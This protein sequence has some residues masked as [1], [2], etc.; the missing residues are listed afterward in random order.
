MGTVP[1]V[2]KIIDVRNLATIFTFAALIALMWIALNTENHQKTVII[3]IVS[4]ISE[5]ND[6]THFCS[7]F[8]VRYSHRIF[9]T[10]K[11]NFGV[12]FRAFILFIYLFI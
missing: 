4:K 10:F 8:V 1:L 11:F 3:M 7:M 9:Q 2:E 5:N 12:D 6:E